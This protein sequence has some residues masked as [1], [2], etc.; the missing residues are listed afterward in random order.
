MISVYFVSRRTDAYGID[1][2]D[3][4]IHPCDDNAVLCLIPDKLTL[5]PTVVART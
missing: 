2:L 4:N 5:K 1:R 3:G